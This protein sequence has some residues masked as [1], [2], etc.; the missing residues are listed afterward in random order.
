[1]AYEIRSTDHRY[2]IINQ[3]TL[4]LEKEVT[5]NLNVNEHNLVWL[6]AEKCPLEDKE[7]CVRLDHKVS[8]ICMFLGFLS[9][10]GESIQCNYGGSPIDRKLIQCLTDPPCN[11]ITRIFIPP[12]GSIPEKSH[13][14]ATCGD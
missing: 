2:L 12:S 5:S 6:V 11:K 13:A 10:I 1:M 9:E 14:Y 7:S 3:G 4:P 8:S